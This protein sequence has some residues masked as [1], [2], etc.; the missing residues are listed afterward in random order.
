M[1]VFWRKAAAQESNAVPSSSAWPSGRPSS[2]RP[3]RGRWAGP[4]PHH[5]RPPSLTRDPR[6][7][8]PQHTVGD[9]QAPGSLPGA[10]RLR[11]EGPLHSRAP[12]PHGDADGVQRARRSSA[13]SSFIS[14]GS[15]RATTCPSSDHGPRSG[16]TLGTG[17]SGLCPLVAKKPAALPPRTGL[18]NPERGS[19][20]QHTAEFSWQ[21]EMVASSW[22]SRHR[23]SGGEADGSRG[24]GCVKAQ[25]RQG[26][27]GRER[28]DL[29]WTQNGP[30]ARCIIYSHK[31]QDRSFIIKCMSA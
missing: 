9:T 22:P 12:T 28:A 14:P 31:R 6:A 20:T 18:L 16:G 1:T 13:L 23:L 11:G 21:L 5:P 26:G 8:F 29:A 10:A 17:G 15:L 2:T 30:E 3:C 24:C 7:G 4:A 19:Y 27:A 25:G